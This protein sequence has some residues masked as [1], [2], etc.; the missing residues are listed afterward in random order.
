MAQTGTWHVLIAIKWYPLKIFY[1]VINWMSTTQEVLIT[2]VGIAQFSQVLHCLT[3][4]S[5]GTTSQRS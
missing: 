2:S 5:Q 1:T 3:L 4:D